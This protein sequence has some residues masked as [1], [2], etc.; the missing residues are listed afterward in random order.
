MSGL[1]PWIAAVAIA[2]AAFVLLSFLMAVIKAGRPLSDNTARLLMITIAVIYTVFAVVAQR[3]SNLTMPLGFAVFGA[4][5]LAEAART[6]LA[7]WGLWGL[8]L[9]LS[10]AMLGLQLVDDR[11]DPWLGLIIAA[12]AAMLAL[13]AGYVARRLIALSRTD[14][15]LPTETGTAA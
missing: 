2:G 3:W 6:P 9:A 4:Y 7:R 10:A 5:A 1:A 14:T 8:G 11:L 13:Y 15:P 12:F